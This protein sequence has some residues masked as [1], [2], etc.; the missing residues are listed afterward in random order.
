MTP[1]EVEEQARRRYNVLNDSF[2]SSDEIYKSIYQAEMILARE[3]NVIEASDTSTSTVAG[4]RAYAYPTRCLGIK[5]L[6]YA[7]AK[8]KPIEFREDDSLTLSNSASTS[9][10]TPQYY[11]EWDD[12]AYLRP[13]PDAVGTLTF[14]FYSEP[15][16]LTTSSTTLSTPV[17]CHI[18]LVDYVVAELAAKEGNFDVSD[19][20]MD[21]WNDYLAK[22]K[23]QT[24]KRKRRDGFAVVKDEES[25]S[26][27]ILGAV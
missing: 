23:A 3:A 13:I 24:A 1:A 27:T 21:K 17:R 8:L 11:V 5:R 20:Y 25:L 15:T 22:E 2:Y 18:H 16:P 9:Q 7:G 12:T 26:E 10:G 4:T 6:E 14:Y 19:R